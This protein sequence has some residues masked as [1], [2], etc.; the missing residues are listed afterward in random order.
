MIKKYIIFITLVIIISVSLIFIIPNNNDS[1]VK[2]KELNYNHQ[3]SPAILPNSYLLL[4][5]KSYYV[6]KD[7]L[8]YN[9]VNPKKHGINTANDD[10][11]VPLE[12]L[13]T[14]Q[15]M[16]TELKLN[17][18]YIFSGFRTYQKQES[19]YQYYQ[20]DNYSA[21]PGHSEHHTGFAL[22]L[23]ILDI[24]LEVNFENSNEFKILYENSYKFGFI[25]RY[26][27]NKTSITGYYYEP[28]HFRYVGLIHAKYIYIND[29]TLEEYIFQNF[30]I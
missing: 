9:L 20:D 18:L 28:W 2:K 22:D 14:Y 21:R 7:Y 15:R 10:V 24:G 27:K 12:V 17:N 30:Y 4:V 19:L 1:C 29:L 11:L 13:L 25:L 8:A 3:T 5:N 6:S 23:S 26:P 16:I